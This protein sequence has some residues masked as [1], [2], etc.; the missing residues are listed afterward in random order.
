MSF[1]SCAIIGVLHGVGVESPTQLLALASATVIG[2]KMVGLTLLSSF[3]V[4]MVISNMAVALL[5]IH[6]FQSAKRRRT[7][8]LVLSLLSAVLSAVIGVQLLLS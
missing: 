3:V 1:R 2:S 8:F 4:G 6:G 7:V 5:A